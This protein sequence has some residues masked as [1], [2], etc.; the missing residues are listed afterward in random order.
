MPPWNFQLSL[1]LPLDLDDPPPLFL[2][3]AAIMQG[4]F[5]YCKALPPF[6]ANEPGPDKRPCFF[7][8]CL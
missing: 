3:E 7:F 1:S 2:C 8:F 4:V 6:H 5:Q